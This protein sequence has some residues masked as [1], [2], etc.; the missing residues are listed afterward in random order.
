MIKLEQ[1]MKLTPKQFE[2]MID[3]SEHPVDPDQ[4]TDNKT[5]IEIVELMH[6]ANASSNADDVRHLK[7]QF[8]RISEH[9]KPVAGP[10][11][12]A[13]YKL[14]S[15][16]SYGFATGNPQTIERCRSLANALGATVEVIT[17]DPRLE[18]NREAAGKTLVVFSPPIRPASAEL[19]QMLED[20][21]KIAAQSFGANGEI[22]SR[23]ILVF[24]GDPNRMNV[25]CGWA[26]DE[27]KR[28]VLAGLKR[29]IRQHGRLARY[30]YVAE[31]WA[32]TDMDVRPTKSKNRT[33]HLMI[34]ATERDALPIGGMF[35]I[36]RHA[37]SSKPALGDWEDMSGKIQRS[38]LLDLFDDDDQDV[39]GAPMSSDQPVMPAFMFERRSHVE[40]EAGFILAGQLVVDLPKGTEPT[41]R[42]KRMVQDIINQLTAE[43]R[44]GF[45]PAD[46]V[47]C[48]WH[49]GTKPPNAVDTN[50]DTNDDK[51]IRAWIER[52][53]TIGV[54]VDPRPPS[55]EG[56]RLDSDALAQM[57]LLKLNS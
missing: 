23:F 39:D 2:V 17:N 26:N 54:R 24:E 41:E 49:G 11:V 57:G 48:G 56:P 43:A 14:S 1:K 19:V 5:I 20:V 10:L 3:S 21:K 4:F 8:E 31:V 35:E 52:S 34:T 32:S 45:M 18:S 30:A 15:G 25:P 27:E 36:K 46:A 40:H 47:V 55:D 22:A 16:K 28:E 6:R 29:T 7:D 51:I 44:S 12:W 50:I 42:H 13:A 9:D 38:P 53:L 33:E 37:L